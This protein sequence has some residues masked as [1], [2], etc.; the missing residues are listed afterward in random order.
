MKYLIPVTNQGFVI[1]IID[2]MTGFRIVGNRTVRQVFF[3]R[4]VD[5]GINDGIPSRFQNQ[6]VLADFR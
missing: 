4:F 3:H 5:I 2:G 6:N 1:G